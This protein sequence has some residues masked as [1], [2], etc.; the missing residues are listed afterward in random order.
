[1][2][3]THELG[4]RPGSM[5]R[6]VRAVEAPAD[7]GVGGVVGVPE[8]SE[9]ELSIRLEAVMEGVLASGTAQASISGE[10]ARCL[11]PFDD[12]LVVEWQEL[13]AYPESEPDPEADE[14]DLRVIDDMI[15]LEQP[16]RDALVL[17]L[18][19]APVCRD[20]CP[21]LCAQCGARLADDPFHEH[22]YTDPRWAALAE[23]R[24]DDTNETGS[25]GAGL[26]E[27]T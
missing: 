25:S 10:C 14:A 20:D 22:A 2:L 23:L 4:R 21:G 6:F 8:G 1:M 19:L 5:M 3:D 15:D 13:Y 7:V 27:E 12:H 24:I 26:T 9:I 11:D 16:V 18:P 17:A